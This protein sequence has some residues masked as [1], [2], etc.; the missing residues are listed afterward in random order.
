[1]SSTPSSNSNE[2]VTSDAVQRHVKAD[3]SDVE[4]AR[5]ARLIPIDEVAARAG[6]LPEEVEPYGRHKAK[7]SLSALDRLASAPTGRLINVTAI[8]PTPAGEGKT[9]TS[10]GLTQGLGALGKRVMLCL[11]EPSLGPVFGVKGGA[12]GGGYSQVVP[13]EDINLHFT[14]DIHAVT[15]AH[16]LLA[17]L[18]DNHLLQGNALR[19][20]ANAVT[21]TRVLDI[22]DRALR[23]CVVGLGG[24]ANGLPR[25]TGFEITAASEIMAILA[26]ADGIADM[27]ARLARM[28]VAFD[29]EGAPVTA[30][31]LGATGAMTILLKDAIKPNLVQTLEGQPAFMHAGPFA[32]IAH[33]NNSVLATRLALKLSDYV[34]TE[35]GFGADLG[36]E[37]FYDI[38]APRAGFRSDVAVVV[39]TLR[40]LKA[41]GGLKDAEQWKKPDAAAL[42]AGFANLDRHLDNVARFGVPAVVAIN[43]FR[44]DTAEELAMVVDHCRARGVRAE[45]SEVVARGGPGGTAL[46]AAVLETLE[47]TPSRFAPL[48]GDGLSIEEKIHRVATTLYGAG[49]VVYEKKAQRDLGRLVKL[50]FGNLPICIARTQL[51]FTDDP[52]RKGAPTGWEMHVRE[53]RPSAGAGFLVV[54]TGEI[55]RMPGLP[56]QPAAVG[57]DIDE[58]GHITGLF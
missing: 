13:M 46:A 34:V 24:R 3:I 19:I 15:A 22:S 25:E 4:I 33:G 51:S 53:I 12:A 2:S 27:K 11:R 43:R 40:A 26:L 47:S 55:L 38:V 9:C 37:K 20:D 50:G 18:I 14:G 6:L 48:Y 39:A 52:S 57:M 23:A 41:H 54:L 8:T 32:N 16:N 30:D 5:R 35:S 1:M 28:V 49:S 56:S 17:A 42:R 10:V 44:D 31:Q 58:N 29:Q 36:L 7:I 21:W 45:I